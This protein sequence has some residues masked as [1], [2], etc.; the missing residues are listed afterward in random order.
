VRGKLDVR[1]LTLVGLRPALHA[2]DVS[3]DGGT[4]D[5]AGRVEYTPKQL[6]LRSIQVRL[7]GAKIDYVERNAE[8][9]RRMDVARKA[10]R[11]R[12]RPSRRRASTCRRRSSG[13]A[14]VGIVNK[15]PIRRIACG[16]TG[17]A[18]DVRGF[19][20]QRDAR[21]GSATLTD[22]STAAPAR[23]A[24]GCSRQP[25]ASPTSRTDLRVENV[26]LTAIETTSS[27]PRA[28]STSP[29][30]TCRS[31]S[32][33]AVLIGRVDGLREAAHSR[34]ERLRPRFR[35]RGRGRSG[36]LYEAMVGRRRDRADETAS[37]TRWR[38]S[39]PSRGR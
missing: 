3:V 7:D 19:S 36:Q 31:Y 14:S 9:E 18:S 6:R 38:R 23:P 30:A 8:T 13:N 10:R 39:R 5:A 20:N 24:G 35:T 15:T 27:A 11:R 29:A 25:V 37:T 16:S 17:L 22:A 33:I 1:D 21:R 34:H 12:A 28:A 4:L 32:E 26:D 2:A